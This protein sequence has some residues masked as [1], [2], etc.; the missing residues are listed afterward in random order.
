MTDKL[1]PYI[2][3]PDC[4]QSLVNHIE[5]P[6]LV[7]DMKY[8]VLMT[9]H[10]LPGTSGDTG[11]GSPFPHCYKFTRNLS[12]PCSGKSNPCPMQKVLKTKKQVI[13]THTHFDNLFNKVFVEITA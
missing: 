3:S 13:M 4:L 10:K 11:T 6:T 2:N 8:Q 1:V 5:H 9:N 7:I 12:K